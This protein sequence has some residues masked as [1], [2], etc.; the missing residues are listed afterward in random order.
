VGAWQRGRERQGKFPKVED[1]E[2]KAR[3]M[4]EMEKEARWLAEEI[5]KDV[6]AAS[7]G[8]SL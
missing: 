7:N 2:R 3:S 1:E 6:K 5:L 8:S 4:E